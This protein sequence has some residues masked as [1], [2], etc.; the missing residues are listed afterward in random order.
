MEKIR[1]VIIE[2]L[3]PSGNG[4]EILVKQCC[5][6]IEVVAVA[7][8]SANGMKAILGN[9]PDLVLLDS[10]LPGGNGFDISA[11]VTSLGCKVILL[12]N[13]QEEAYKAMKAHASGFI[14]RPVTAIE[15]NETLDWVTASSNGDGNPGHRNYNRKNGSAGL[16]NSG[17][18]MLM[19][20]N[21]FN[22]LETG[23]IIKLEANGNYTDIYLVGNHK[24][25][26]CK[27][28]K[29]FGFLLKDMPGF[30]RTH[31][32]FIVNLDYVRSFS[33]Q[34]IIRLKEDHTAH[35]G[36]SYREEFL[37]YFSHN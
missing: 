9:K 28:L 17:R 6:N 7:N 18:I 32:S 3:Q 33:K 11:S 10:E 19:D 23:E 34:G 35:C 8:N 25:T 14:L 16:N 30:M 21:G 12:G 27:M 20:S 29:E 36:D 31:R 4:L 2:N 37:A 1:T 24:L 22:I 13:H 26:Y 5:R 15:L